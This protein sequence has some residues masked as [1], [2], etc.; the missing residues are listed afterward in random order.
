MGKAF[1][2]EVKPD[3]HKHNYTS[4]TI[5]ATCTE[6]GTITYT[7]TCGDIYTEVIPATGHK[8]VIPDNGKPATTTEVGYTA[9]K[10]CNDCK[11]WIEGHIEIP[12]L[13]EEHIHKYI[14]SVTKEATCSEEGITT[15]ICECG[16]SYTEVIEMLEH[17]YKNEVR[18]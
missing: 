17:S 9:G 18:M 12:M 14:A 5:S 13:E 6:P 16:E 11:T 15:Y 2:K 1:I 3:I 10:Y 4:T 8:N 7:C